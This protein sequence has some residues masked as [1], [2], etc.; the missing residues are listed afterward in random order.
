MAGG[1]IFP[2]SAYPA[3][4]GSVFPYFY[5]GGGGNASPVDE[6]LGV[7]AS[8]SSD[9]TWELRF[10]LP[11]TIPSGTMKLRLLGMANATS[12]VAKITISDAVVAAGSS[13]S[14]ASLTAETQVSLTWTAADVYVESK[15]ALTPT[16]VGNSV[17]VVALVFNHTSWTLAQISTWVVS[18]IWE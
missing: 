12:G 16:A 18:L 10:M 1:A 7:A 5:S 8:I 11:P 14:A 9:A 6:G 2:Y 15:T 17:L 4:A 13:P 3:T